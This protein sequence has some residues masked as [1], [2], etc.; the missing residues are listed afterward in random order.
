MRKLGLVC[1]TL[2]VCVWIIVSHSPFKMY[3]DECISKNMY[4]KEYCMWMYMETRKD[5][6]WL[7]RILLELGS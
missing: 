2:V 4:G 1:I 7:R 6:S 3:V 5:E